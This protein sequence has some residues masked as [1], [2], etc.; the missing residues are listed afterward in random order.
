MNIKK[1]KYRKE[2]CNN[3]KQQ[4]HNRNLTKI[5]NHTPFIDFIFPFYREFDGSPNRQQ[6]NAETSVSRRRTINKQVL[7]QTRDLIETR[8]SQMLS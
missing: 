2:R 6:T 1:Y 3:K 8:A 7:K 4:P 5:Q